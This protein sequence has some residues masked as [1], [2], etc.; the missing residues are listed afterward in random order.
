[1]NTGYVNLN[2]MDRS[3]YPEDDK[4]IEDSLITEK[5]DLRT[6]FAYTS[7][8]TFVHGVIYVD[9]ADAGNIW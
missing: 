9:D 7:Y 5:A 8:T 3:Y 6:Q 1:M 4:W 2:I